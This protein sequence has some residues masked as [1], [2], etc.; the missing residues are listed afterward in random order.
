[1]V[2]GQSPFIGK[3]TAD[4]L[5]AVLDR[6]PV[7]PVSLR[8]DVP[9]GLAAIIARALAKGPADR[10]QAMADVGDALRTVGRGL[11]AQVVSGGHP[12]LETAAVDAPSAAASLP[13]PRPT[14]KW[15]NPDAP[16]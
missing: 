9:A 1:M 10:F 4:I 6:D 12:E 7:E 11:D 14:G 2:T 15:G 13:G 16:W 3:T 8:T 5:A